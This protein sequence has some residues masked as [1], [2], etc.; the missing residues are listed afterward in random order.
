MIIKKYLFFIFFIFFCSNLLSEDAPKKIILLE[1][2]LELDKVDVIQSE[3]NAESENEGNLEEVISTT[4]SKENENLI[5]IDDIPKEFNDWYGILS[6]EEGGLGWLMWG[7]TNSFLA[8]NLLERTNFSTQSPTL[9]K[10]SS[11]VLMSRAQKPKEKNPE[12]ITG[13]LNDDSGLEYLKEKIRI[14]SDLGDTLNINKLIE[15][16]PLEI[17]DDN[18]Y[19]LIFDLRRSDK[20]IPY[21]C[22]ELQKKKFDVKKNIEKRKTL[23]ACNIAKRKYNQAYLALDLLENDSSESLPYI[24]TV[25]K[26]LEEPLVENLLLEEKN[27]KNRNF[28]I[29]SLSDH[30]IAKKIFSK[31]SLILDQIIYDM[32]LY[33]IKDQIESLEKLVTKGLYSPIMLKN[34]Y[35]DYYKTVKDKVDID[36]LNN[37]ESENTLDVRVSLFYLINNTISDIERAKLLNLLWLKA[38]EIKIEGNISFKNVH[39]SYPSRRDIEVLRDISF[40]VE[41]GKQIAF[42]GPSG[43]GKSTIAALMF[44]FYDAESGSISIDGKP[45]KDYDLSEIRNQMALVPQ[46]VLLFGGTIKE[47]IEYGKPGATD[48]EIFEAAKKANALE[49]IESFP[50]KFDTIVGDRGIQLSGGQKQRIAIARAILK[51][52]SIL[53]LD[54]ATSALDSE[55]ERLVQEALDRLMEG[56][57]SLVIAHR[58]STIKNADNI[59]VLDNG[60]IKETGTH[61]ELMKKDNGIY[62]NLSTIQLMAV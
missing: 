36:S 9:F 7:S 44:R 34:S 5:V 6:S 61:A 45:I 62:K 46:E 30:K 19:N 47:N 16:I 14:L 39:F 57:T 25:R 15:N 22:N 54:E 50:E 26:F 60:K 33:S 20:D 8:K 51:N 40:E 35:I 52:P 1:E 41:A 10:L 23:I 12:G 32:K 59:I 24:K 53:V 3:K 42:V 11:K 49:F 29:I 37:V 13:S 27:I 31:D 21:I 48:E 43:A 2:N 18:F 28:K 56:R 4:E 17:K 55:S 38:K 58:L